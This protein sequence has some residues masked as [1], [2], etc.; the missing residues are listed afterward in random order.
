M[1]VF[2]D[3]E[4]SHGIWKSCRGVASVNKTLRY[5]AAA[6]GVGRFC[7]DNYQTVSIVAMKLACSI[8]TKRS[9]T[10]SPTNKPPNPP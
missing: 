4:A 5:A 7:H 2:I 6:V 8:Y 3:V 9:E 10:T 1:G